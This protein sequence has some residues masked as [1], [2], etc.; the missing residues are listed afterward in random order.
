MLSLITPTSGSTLIS[1]SIDIDNIDSVHRMATF[2][3]H[4]T[5]R[6]NLDLL[7]NHTLVDRRNCLSFLPA[8]IAALKEWQEIRASIYRA[9]IAHPE[10]VA[11]NAFLIDLVNRALDHEIVTKNDWFISDIEFEQRLL[12]SDQTHSIATQL[13]TGCD[14]ALVDYVWFLSSAALQ[15]PT[16]SVFDRVLELDLPLALEGAEY[17]FWVESKLI[18]RSI[19]AQIYGGGHVQGRGRFSHPYGGVGRQTRRGQGLLSCSRSRELASNS[20]GAC[21]VSTAEL[22]VQC[23]IPRRL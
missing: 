3:G 4:S 14:Y 6:Q 21:T 20:S 13:I 18:S 5:A 22:G 2:L 10:C 8:G 12:T 17:F 16:G 15:S 7:L 9:I 23:C 11:Y 19:S 1:A